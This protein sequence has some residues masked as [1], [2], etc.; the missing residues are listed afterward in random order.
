LKSFAT[1]TDNFLRVGKEWTMNKRLILNFIWIGFSLLVLNACNL[2]AAGATSQSGSQAAYTQAAQTIVAQLTQQASDTQSAE[3]T[4]VASAP[5]AT[6]TAT[7]PQATAAAPTPTATTI[8]PTPA[9]PTA[10]PVLA[11]CDQVQF[12]KDVTVAD[13]SLLTPGSEFSKVWRLKNIGTCTWDTDYTLVFS[14]GDRMQATRVIPLEDTVHPGEKIDM[15]VDFVAPTEQGRYRSLWMLSNASGKRFGIGD[16]ADQAFWAEIRVTSPNENFAY[17][18]AA[19]MC[20]ATW[21]SSAGSLPCPGDSA[22]ADGSAI[23]LDRPVL[24]GG[25]HENESTLWMRPA[26]EKNGW[27]SGIYPAY[28]V[29]D[30]DHFLADIGCLQD[31]DGCKVLFSLDYQVSGGSKKNLGQWTETY[32]GN[33]YRVDVDLSSLAGKKVQLIL[34]VTNQGKASQANAFWL[35]PSVRKGTPTPPP[36]GNV[37]AVQAARQRVATDLGIDVSSLSVESFETAEWTDSCLG[38]HLPDQVCADVI[39][40]GYRVVLSSGSARYEAHTNEDG[41]IVF[42]FEI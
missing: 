8:P 13:G 3:L 37:P 4:R 35:A 36:G 7:P 19:D 24:E 41:S 14:S 15:K 16:N 33:I 31:S 27:I 29:R 38:V 25:R 17:D 39:I 9:P 18:L 20:L 12:I 2:L 26:A 30:G 22:S 32:D 10:T 28:K 1:T 6:P 23:L 5:A 34:S 42:W 21:R 11:L 40:P